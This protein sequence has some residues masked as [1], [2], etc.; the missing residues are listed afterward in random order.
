MP[1]SFGQQRMWFLHSLEGPS[2]TNNIPLAIRL[3]GELNTAALEAAWGDVVVRHETLRTRYPE[4]GGSACQDIADAA[5]VTVR[6]TTARVGADDVEQALAAGVEQGFR[7]ESELPWRVTLFEVAPDDHVLLIVVHHIAADGWSMGVLADDLATAYAARA[8]GR[9]PGWAPPAVQYADFTLWQRELLA[10]D[11]EDGLFRRQAAFWSETL[12]GLPEHLKLPFDRPRPPVANHRGAFLPFTVDAAAHRRLLEIARDCDATLFM[13]AQAA[14]VVLLSRLGAGEDI[15]LGTPI[16]G[17][18]DEAVDDLV[19]NFL[20][21][22]VLRTD[23]GGNPAFTELVARVRETDLAAYA[24]QDLPFEHL[25]EVLNPVRSLAR[26]PLFQVAFALQNAPETHFDAPGLASR[27]VPVEM[28]TSKFDLSVLMWERRDAGGAAAG[29]ECYLEFATDLFDRT[30]AEGLVA[31]L[32]RVLDQVTAD[33]SVRAG[34]VDVLGEDERS[35]VTAAAAADRADA[36]GETVTRRFERIAA[37][38]AEAPAVRYGDATLTYGELDARANRCAWYLRAKGV[39]PGARVAV[40]LDRSADLVTVLLGIAKAGAVAVPVDTAYPVERVRFLL[41]D[42]APVLVMTRSEVAE[43]LGHFPAVPLPVRVPPE[44]G[45]YVMYTSGSTGTPKGVV[46]THANVAALALDPCWDGIGTGR[47]LFHAP[48]TFDA[49][50]LELWVPLLNGG[51]VVVA[52]AA[53]LDGTTLAGLVEE[54]ALTAVHVTAGLFRVL[55]QESPECFAGLQHVLT[56]GDVVPAEAV[57]RVAEVCPGAAVHHLY[58]P[59][60]TTLCAT[61][62]T[63]P[64]G[65]QAPA[66]LPIGRPRDGVRVFVLDTHL[67]P[68]PTDVAGELYVA[69]CGVAHGYLGR[70]ALTAERFVA[71]PYG[72]GRMYRTGDLVRWDRDGNLVFLGRADDQVK[73]RGFRI[74]PAE[75][76]A[77]LG[78]APGVDQVAVV[79]REDRPGDK[80][81]VAY[82]VGD[83]SGVRDFAADR[84]PDYMIPGTLVPLDALP[85]T[86]NGKVD[87]AA[88]PA[89]DYAAASA[90]R[91]PRTPLE[92][93]FCR[94]FA[95]VLGLGA[96]GAHPDSGP[97]TDPGIGADANF[98]ELGGDSIISLQ[99]VARAAR[100]GYRISATDV[101]QHKTPEALA[102]VAEPVTEDETRHDDSAGPVPLTPVMR[103]LAD[104]NALAGPLFQTAMVWTPTGLT[105]VE[106]ATALQAVLDHHGALRFQ[107]DPGSGTDVDGGLHVR[108]PGEVRATDL[109]RTVRLPGPAEQITAT[110]VREQCAAATRR[111]DPHTGTVLQAVW[112]DAGLHRPGRLFLAAH[113]LC[114]DSASWRI[115]L[116]DLALAHEAV[117][118]GT[119]PVLPPVRTS[120]RRW[121]ELLRRTANDPARAAE[122]PLWKRVGAPTAP[123]L[124]KAPAAPL[125]PKAPTAP[126]PPKAPTA[127]TA[128]FLPKAPSGPGGSGG[129]GGSRGSGEM[130]TTLPP[131][132]TTAL[133]TTVPAA[134]HADVTEVLLAALALAVAD[135]RG[136][137]GAV[138][139][140][141]ERHGRES[142]LAPGV[143]LS[144][145]V[146][147]FTSVHPVRLGPGADRPGALDAEAMLKRV[148]EQVRELPEHGIGH[149]LLRHLN[150]RT[151]GTLAA[152]AEPPILFNYLGRV[153]AADRPGAATA[154]TATGDPHPP[155]GVRTHPVDL[156]ART[157]DTAEGPRLTAHWAWDTALVSEDGM[158]RLAQAWSRAAEALAACAEQGD[159]GGRTPSDLDLI[160]LTQDDIDQLE[161]EWGK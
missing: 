53:D 151:A 120:F 144:R 26:H 82:V 133:L 89:P 49:S 111:L 31:R 143:D 101:F 77:V 131:A 2:P 117:A 50:T 148:K 138:L 74:E 145:T 17:R 7:I 18:T 40:M 54:H 6:L 51:C 139:V 46:A 35:R 30:T 86:G 14:V 158:R 137:P 93:L 11:P 99:L 9:A 135:W 152:S 147:W 134:F 48:H 8:E 27:L 78:Q 157:E 57:A 65:A 136:R 44:S 84:L 85:I 41:E 112:F 45:L 22:L 128:P 80:R 76:E 83:A 153:P 108:P 119:E 107:L 39:T 72:G 92:I 56:G 79:V 68:V 24:H 149:G 66:V 29:L 13:V 127:P 116:D 1:L 124:P 91:A 42:S 52:P 130:S 62:H 105:S 132:V 150:P 73:V 95:E 100:A 123:L 104:R 103:Q 97:D 156:D 129:Y 122:L 21:T 155:E 15:P 121:A 109:L 114:V 87:R 154:W 71:C 88:L 96:E 47:V 75:I 140:D 159:A 16:A 61:T 67:H 94:M 81:L 58:G 102:L 90:G 5:E 141:L 125:P 28:S 69:G 12:A 64:P 98:F 63:L 34:R 146:G 33:P 55:A 160:S 36:R 43:A 161:T 59:T 32:L 4:H 106:L 110:I 23:V 118:A 126:L 115:L 37:R 38:H 142:G 113:H 60:E 19:G 3:T 70:A 25:V 10:Q 20:N